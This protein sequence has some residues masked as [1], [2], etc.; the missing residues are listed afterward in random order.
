MII[1]GLRNVNYLSFYFAD[2]YVAY[3]LSHS[4]KFL[5]KKVFKHQCENSFLILCRMDTL[6]KMNVFISFVFFFLSGFYEAKKTTKRKEKMSKIPP[7]PYMS[8]S[9]FK[10][11]S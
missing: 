4:V 11:R 6:C 3:L 5:P 10:R 8:M 2:K 9:A 1:K 7:L